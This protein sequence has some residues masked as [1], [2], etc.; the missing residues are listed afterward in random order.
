MSAF[1]KLLYVIQP[2]FTLYLY[3]ICLHLHTYQ[4]TIRYM[5]SW[6]YLALQV[7]IYVLPSAEQEPSNYCQQDQSQRDGHSYNWSLGT[8]TGSSYCQKKEKKK[9]GINKE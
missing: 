9:K 3:S 1:N 6:L 2:C 7:Y 8:L 5:L 4:Y